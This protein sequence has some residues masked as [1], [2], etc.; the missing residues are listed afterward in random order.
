MK[1]NEKTWQEVLNIFSEEFEK[2]GLNKKYDVKI[3]TTSNEFNDLSMLNIMEKTKDGISKVVER[4]PLGI[5]KDHIAKDRDAFFNK[6]IK[7]L[8]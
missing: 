4:L 1:N 7:A 8:N 2:S 3:Y 6:L 5:V